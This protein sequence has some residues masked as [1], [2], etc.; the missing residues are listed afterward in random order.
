VSMQ[1]TLVG[2]AP[3][4]VFTVVATR[5][6]LDAVGAAAVLAFPVALG[7]V[8][9]STRRAEAVQLLEITALMVFGGYAQVALTAPTTDAFLAH[10]GRAA[11]AAPA[12][13]RP[14]SP[15]V[16]HPGSPG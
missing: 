5:S 13:A 7:L 9:R 15:L 4:S 3:W 1:K 2:F 12:G 6:G 11:A 8:I 16:R 14:P 10:H